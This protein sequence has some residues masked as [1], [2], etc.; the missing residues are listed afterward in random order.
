MDSDERRLLDV[1][2]EKVEAVNNQK[3]KKK[4][5]GRVIERKYQ[6][7]KEGSLFATIYDRL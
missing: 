2:S 7:N 4:T 3:K 6:G 5:A 1:N